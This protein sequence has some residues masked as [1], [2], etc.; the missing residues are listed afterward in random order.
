MKKIIYIILGMVITIGIFVFLG[1]KFPN[2]GLF[3]YNLMEI[4]TAICVSFGIYYLTKINEEKKNK[5]N[6]VEDII[7]L[8]QKR[9]N[10]VFSLP[11]KVENKA[12]YLHTFKYLDNKILILENMTKHLKCDD[13]IRNIKIEKE[14]LD[15]F[16]T[17]N[18]NL[19][20]NYF[21]GET[22]KEKIPNIL[23]NIESHLDSIILKIY[24][25]TEK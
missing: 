24:G 10:S 17:E 18:I 21:T 5:N 13:E 14:K 4:I 16:I 3:Q 12:E 11:I 2:C 7:E 1:V 23:G 6:K 20:D 22:V 25:S 8:I 15:D 9:L 19:G